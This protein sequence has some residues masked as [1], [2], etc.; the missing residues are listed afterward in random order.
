MDLAEAAIYRYSLTP[1][2]DHWSDPGHQFR[3][4]A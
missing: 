2:R 4:H 3:K 1:D